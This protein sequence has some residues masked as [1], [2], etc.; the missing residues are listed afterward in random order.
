MCRLCGNIA[1][2]AESMQF[3]AFQIGSQQF[4][5]EIHRVLE[6]IGY[7]EITPLPGAPPAIEGLIDVR[8]SLIPVVDLRKRLGLREIRNTMQT[9]IL[10]LR[11]NHGKVGVIVDEAD[12]VHTIPLE[13]IQAPPEQG[14]DLVLA[15]VRH[16][17]VLFIILELERVLS[18]DEQMYMYGINVPPQTDEK[19]K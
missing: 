6:V 13:N 9:R 10:I 16:E 19:R 4:A 17:N 14:S 7:C 2:M 5:V 3:V 1:A 18:G 11:I 12:Q 8:G 15:V